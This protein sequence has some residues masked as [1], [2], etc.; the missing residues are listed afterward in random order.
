M[1]GPRRDAS[2]DFLRIVAIVA[3][4]AGHVWNEPFVR[5]ALFSWHVPLFFVL[6]G[7]LTSAMPFGTLVRRRAQT[8]LVPYVVWLVIIA[9]TFF[10]LVDPMRL[11]AGGAYI[12]RPFSAFWFVTALFVATL[13]AHPIG[14]LP[15]LWQWLI[16]SVLL[17]GGYL[18][19]DVIALVPLDAGVALACV[20]FI[21]AGRT[22]RAV[23]SRIPRPLWVGV[24]L[25]AVAAAVVASGISAPLDLKYG[26]F[27]VPVVSVVVAVMIS[28]GMILVAGEALRGVGQRTSAIITQVA[29]GGFMV[30][31]THTAV[32][33]AIGFEGEGRVVAFT[34]S[35]L[36]PW[37][38]AMIALRTP[39]ARA[40]TGAPRQ[41]VAREERPAVEP[42]LTS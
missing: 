7:Y 21:V 26:D 14:R 8:L 9:V 31:L 32:L 22:L 19:G 33:Q 12:G 29:L 37:A 1:T 16:A 41:G 36:L 13:V 42:V 6:T 17:A 34:L 20:I 28:F 3:I 27:G 25:L 2:I 15:L 35:L 4:V 11:L 40:L 5:S 24:G 23:R 39:L 18:A 38:A 10:A 30:V